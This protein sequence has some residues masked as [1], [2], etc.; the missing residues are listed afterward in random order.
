MPLDPLS[1][2]D[3]EPD[4]ADE[5]AAAQA[6]GFSIGLLDMDALIEGDTRAACRKLGGRSGPALLRGWMLRPTDYARLD[7]ALHTRDIALITAPAHYEACHHL[8]GWYDRLA[9]GTPRSVWVPGSPPPLSACL[10]ALSALG[11]EAAIVKDYVKSH[12]HAWA[13]ACFIPDTSDLD[14]AGRV[15]A[16]F[17]AYQGDGLSGGVVLRAFEA[18][19][20]AGPH[21]ESGMPRSVEARIFVL[22]GRPLVSL[23]YWPGVA[24]GEGPPDAALAPVLAAIDS[25]LYTVD[26]AQKTDGTWM[27]ME[28][29]D[30]QVSGL[31]GTD[32]VAFY[33]ALADGLSGRGP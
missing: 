3:V 33:R 13:E 19:R 24:L 18:L 7:T 15:I 11:S 32:P 10:E 28:V 2:R 8:P 20:P 23:A 17:L 4:F 25:P 29:G 1:E 27:V 9:G 31:Q 14:H 22:D 5:H 6:A 21:P 26:F 12:K 16:A 30:G